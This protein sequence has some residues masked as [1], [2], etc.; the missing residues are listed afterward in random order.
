MASHSA[1]AIFVLLVVVPTATFATTY[2]VGDES[3]WT[4]GF[5][6]QAW[7]QDKTFQVGDKLVFWY[8][9]G[10]HNVFRVNG[11]TFRDCTIPPLVEALTSGNDTITLAT[12]GNKWYICGVGKHC[13]SG[14]KLAITVQVSA[15]TQSPSPASSPPS[16]APYAHGVPGVEKTEYGA[17]A[18]SP[19]EFTPFW[20]YFTPAPS[21]VELA[22][23]EYETPAPPPV[24]S[25]P[26][27]NVSPAPAPAAET[28]YTEKSAKKRPFVNFFRG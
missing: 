3:G 14:Q 12:P 7:A 24:E 18:P 22:T 17:P 27:W 19:A 4:V 20:G 25:V 8:P 5:D 21:P 1:F 11:T 6:Y 10:S 23:W 9:M 15:P 16:P 26:W 28:G 2:T 13:V